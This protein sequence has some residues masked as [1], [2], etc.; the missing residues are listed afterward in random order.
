[1]A[2]CRVFFEVRAEGINI[3]A[4]CF[5][6]SST[7]IPAVLRYHILYQTS[8]LLRHRSICPVLRK[9]L[10]QTSDNRIARVEIIPGG[11]EAVL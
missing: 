9:F 2:K 1:M 6:E 8:T 11:A 7:V 5:K 10:A 4:F 3:G